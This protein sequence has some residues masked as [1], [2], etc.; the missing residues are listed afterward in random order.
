MRLIC[1][2][3]ILNIVFS[4]CKVKSNQTDYP[5]KQLKT[6]TYLALGDSY[7]IGQSVAAKE[8]FPNQ[9]T[10]LLNVD[11]LIV[12]K[13]TIVA[14][15]GWTTDELINAIKTSELKT[16]YSFVTLLIGVNNQYRGYSI[17]KYKIE[18]KQLLETAIQKAG[19]N[20]NKVFVISIPDYGITP[21]AQN[22]D[23]EKIAREIDQYN[24]IALQITK[25]AKANYLDITPISR[26]AKDNPA[27]IAADG[28]HPSAEMYRLW[29]VEL[30]K[31]VKKEVF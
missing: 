1:A 6:Y 11:S 15:T 29:V 21:F 18:F 16:K 30:A 17:D 8:N 13:P 10:A 27:L 2:A 22:S 28:L 20:A 12:E 25:D 5:Q 9:L 3:F 26:E 14:K 7:T 4:S 24:Q 23:R 19:N 31:Q